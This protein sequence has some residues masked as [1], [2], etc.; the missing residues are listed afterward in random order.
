MRTSQESS[1]NGA[2]RREPLKNLSSNNTQFT[3]WS[4]PNQ[5]IKKTNSNTVKPRA[6][7]CPDIDSSNRII[8]ALKFV[9][10]TQQREIKNLKKKYAF[11]LL[12]FHQ[13]SSSLFSSSAATRDHTTPKK[14]RH[15]DSDVSPQQSSSS[16]HEHFNELSKNIFMSP[17]RPPARDRDGASFG[18]PTRT[19]TTGTAG[20]RSRDLPSPL[21]ERIGIYSTPDRIRPPKYPSTA[22]H[23]QSASPLRPT[24]FS[25]STPAETISS[26]SSSSASH[27]SR[28]THDDKMLTS[29]SHRLSELEQMIKSFNL[30]SKPQEEPPRA[31]HPP[32]AASATAPL[33]SSQTP[34]LP[35]AV[36]PPPV[37]HSPLLPI[38]LSKHT[39][40]AAARSS[41]SEPSPPKAE[42]ER[43]DESSSG[44]QFLHSKISTASLDALRTLHSTHREYF[45]PSSPSL[46]PA[47]A[48]SLSLRRHTTQP[49]SP[50]NIFSSSSHSSPTA[51]AG[52]GAP[53]RLPQV[54]LTDLS[55]VQSKMTSWRR[56]YPL[57]PPHTQATSPE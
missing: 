43:E 38:N 30:T 3:L 40:E 27:Q 57:P 12:R 33:P 53:Y 42:E 14:R 35:P 11:C 45:H 49:T 5:G 25:S 50:P 34:P 20:V 44:S 2:A 23:H 29:L 4:D 6:D 48:A 46:S 18:S 26:S 24:L 56:R 52:S 10:L 13:L 55:S 7:A 41:S 36:S 19:T 39:T 32:P 16:G 47:A 17:T 51:A 9:I 37:D 31:S 15:Y 21:V 1:T 22:S 54:P 28:L 8:G